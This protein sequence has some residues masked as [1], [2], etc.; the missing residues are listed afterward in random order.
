MEGDDVFS[1]QPPKQFC[2]VIGNEANGVSQTLKDKAMHKVS[3]PM[4]NGMES[5][6]ASV[7]AGLLMY[8]LKNNHQINK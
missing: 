1:Y 7:S 6:N 3:I 2:L 4:Q 8:M 5:L